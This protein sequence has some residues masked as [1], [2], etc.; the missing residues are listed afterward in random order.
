MSACSE[1]GSARRTVTRWEGSIPYSVEICEADGCPINLA[2]HRRHERGQAFGLALFL[3]IIVLIL[4]SVFAFHD[5]LRADC[6]AHGGQ[7]LPVYGGRG[8][9]VCMPRAEPRA[10]EP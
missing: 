5:S 4:V 1:C 3:V 6:V 7:W 2:A 9:A 10:D 8:G